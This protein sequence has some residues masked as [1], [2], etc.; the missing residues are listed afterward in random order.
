MSELGW[1]SIVRCSVLL[2]NELSRYLA[3][4][5]RHSTRTKEMGAVKS[6]MASRLVRMPTMSVNRASWASSEFR[7]VSIPGSRY[8]SQSDVRLCQ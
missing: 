8:A 4:F 3:K 7:F 6:T 1:L 2:R 5:R